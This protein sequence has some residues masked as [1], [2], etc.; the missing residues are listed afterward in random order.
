MTNEREMLLTGLVPMI[1]GLAYRFHRLA[2][3]F[4]GD[5]GRGGIVPPPYLEATV[6]P[7]FAGPIRFVLWILLC[8]VCGAGLSVWHAVM[9]GL[10]IEQ[11]AETLQFGAGFAV[12]SGF[13]GVRLGDEVR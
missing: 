5:E 4:A 6:L 8:A 13:L 1:F 3:I 9:Q 11:T 7:L 2:W 10:P 12:L